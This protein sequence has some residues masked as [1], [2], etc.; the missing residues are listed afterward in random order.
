VPV[1]TLENFMSPLDLKR[2]KDLTRF[3][4]GTLVAVVV[5]FT[6][7]MPVRRYMD[8]H[9]ADPHL[10]W[11]MALPLIALFATMLFV[12]RNWRRMDELDRKIH[13]EA[14]SFAFISS[15]LVISICEFLMRAGL[16]SIS[17]DWLTL[18]MII[19]WEIGLVLAIKRYN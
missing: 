12:M 13:A 9:P 14:L 17:V 6:V 1:R 19:C 18:A 4:A 10:R 3:T 11:I 8:G 2:K 15:F 7:S 5:Y 16:L